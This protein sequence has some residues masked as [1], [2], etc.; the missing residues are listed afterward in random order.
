MCASEAISRFSYPQSAVKYIT[1]GP[2]LL[3]GVGFFCG[4]KPS[5]K[6][7]LAFLSPSKSSHTLSMLRF[8]GIEGLKITLVIRHFF[9]Q[10]VRRKIFLLTLQKSHSATTYIGKRFLFLDGELRQLISGRE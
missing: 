2:L 4:V 1:E 8:S 7:L 3:L 9:V 6:A 10:G 5:N